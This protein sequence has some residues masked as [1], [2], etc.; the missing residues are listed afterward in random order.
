MYLIYVLIYFLHSHS[1]SLQLIKYLLNNYLSY[2]I[3]EIINQYPM[4]YILSYH[5]IYYIQ[6]LYPYFVFIMK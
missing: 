2:E 5:S 1:S 6:F 4:L 3:V